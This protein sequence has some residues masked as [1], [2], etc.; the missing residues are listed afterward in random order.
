MAP[1]YPGNIGDFSIQ[2]PKTFDYYNWDVSK[3][4]GCLC[5]PEYGDV[6]CSKRMCQYGTDVMDQR[7]DV[8]TV[9]KYQVQRITIKALT[10]SFSDSNLGGDTFALTFKSKLNETFTTVPIPLFSG[11]SDFRSFILHVEQA[12]ERLPNGVI[13]NVDVAGSYSA[14]SSIVNLNISFVGETVQG[15]QHLITVKDYLCGDGC[16]PKLSGVELMPASN[17]I[18]ELQKSDFNSYECG[19]RG[20][21]DYATG[22]C[23][24]F[25]GYN[26]VTCGT[27]SCLV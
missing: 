17:D 7:P 25:A 11:S 23:N 2:D 22:I 18:K 6:D 20:K 19:R 16:S 27:I 3:T 24:C 13:D 10:S 12:L 8:T 15:P 26:G 21:C 4:R 9:G 1:D 5:D 14:S